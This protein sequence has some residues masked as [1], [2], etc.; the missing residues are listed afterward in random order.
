MPR[1]V[2]SPWRQDPPPATLPALP[3]LPVPVPLC[4]E[5]APPALSPGPRPRPP[6]AGSGRS[7]ALEGK[8]TARLTSSWCKRFTGTV[9]LEDCE[10]CHVRNS[11]RLIRTI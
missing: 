6:T 10:S 3:W 5:P 7:P 9:F 11:F 8:G 2:V 1:L 4:A